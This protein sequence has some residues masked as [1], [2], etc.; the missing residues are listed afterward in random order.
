MRECENKEEKKKH[1]NKLIKTIRSN[2][3]KGLRQFYEE[4]ANIIYATAQCFCRSKD[5]INEVV[6][7][8]LVKIWKFSKKL[9]E[10]DNPE[11]WVYIITVNTAKDKMRETY[12]VPLDE[13]VMSKDDWNQGLLDMQSFYWWIKELSEIEQSVMILKFIYRNTFQEISEELNK[14]LTTVTSIYYRGLEKIKN[15]IEKKKN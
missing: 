8:V 15:R 3:E 11:G 13:S 4:Y 10:I 9:T 14:P 6:N 12:T 7:D 2:P 5:K 1:F